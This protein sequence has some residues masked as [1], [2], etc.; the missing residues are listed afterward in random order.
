MNFCVLGAGEKPLNESTKHLFRGIN[1]KRG[2]QVLNVDSRPLPGIDRVQNLQILPQKDSYDPGICWE[3]LGDRMFDVVIAEHIA[4]HIWDRIAFL[5]ECRRILKPGGMLI[6]EVPSWKHAAGHNML[7][8]KSTW[9]RSAFDSNNY[10]SQSLGFFS[11]R[12]EF[13]VA[14]EWLIIGYVQGFVGRMLDRLGFATAYR[15]YL[16]TK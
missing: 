16:R 15:Y 10:V 13:R 3:N 1:Y 7:E 8:H 6:L 5:V 11:E 4:E 2:D 14:F 9:G 12:V